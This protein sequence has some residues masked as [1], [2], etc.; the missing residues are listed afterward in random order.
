MAELILV[1]QKGPLM[2]L[3]KLLYEGNVWIYI[4]CFDIP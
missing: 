2:Y 3:L 4:L 1:F